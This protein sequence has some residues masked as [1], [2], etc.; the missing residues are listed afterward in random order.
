MYIRMGM[1][2]T[3]KQ[4]SI[5]VRTRGK[6]VRGRTKLEQE[7]IWNGFQGFHSNSRAD[8]EGRGII[9]VGVEVE[10]EGCHI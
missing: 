4:Y 8:S 7:Q 3:V 2:A 9:C 1:E 6:K 5:I 10:Y